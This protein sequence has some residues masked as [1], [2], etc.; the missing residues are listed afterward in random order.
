[1]IISLLGR[2]P[3]SGEPWWWHVYEGQVTVPFTEM[4]VEQWRAE[5]REKWEIIGARV[6]NGDFDRERG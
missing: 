4:E 5:E 2:H 6:L 3:I 1:M